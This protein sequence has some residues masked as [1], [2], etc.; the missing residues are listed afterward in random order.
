MSFVLRPA[1]SIRSERLHL[2]PWAPSDA[3]AL[4]SALEASREHL[5]PWLNW[6]HEE[7]LPALQR[8][9]RLRRFRAQFDLGADFTYGVFDRASG[10]VVG[11]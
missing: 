5:V 9:D 2:R 6:A 7:P 11:G 4:S 10:E 1:Y 8:I 3:A